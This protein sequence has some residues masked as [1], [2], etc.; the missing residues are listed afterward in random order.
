MVRRG[1][2]A[3][4]RVRSHPGRSVL[5]N[6]LGQGQKMKVARWRGSRDLLNEDVFLVC[7]DGLHALLED[8]EI[9]EA[10]AGAPSLAEANRRLVGQALERGGTDN[11]SSILVRVRRPG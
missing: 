6:A 11:V 2:L 9:A 8:S 7:S 10:I 5:L 1:M 3:P 4:A